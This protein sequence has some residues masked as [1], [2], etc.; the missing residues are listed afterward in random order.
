[1]RQYVAFSLQ[2]GTEVIV[3]EVAKLPDETGTE[4]AALPDQVVKKAK[5]TFEAAPASAKPIAR[6]VI[7]TMTDIVE[8]VTEVQV[9]FGLKLNA[10]AGVILTSGGVEANFTVAVKWERDKAKK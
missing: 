2:D 10:E 4:P 8:G 6:A 5:D 7:A 9:K 3:A 1:M